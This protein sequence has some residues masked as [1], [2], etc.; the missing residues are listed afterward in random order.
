MTYDWNGEKEVIDGDLI[1]GWITIDGSQVE[2][3]EEAW[4]QGSRVCGEIEKL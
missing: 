2:L 3:D 1:S 4:R